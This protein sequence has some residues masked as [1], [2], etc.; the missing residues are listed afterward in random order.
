M[1]QRLAITIGGLA[2]AGVLAVGLGAAGFAPAARPDPGPDQAE[3]VVEAA[4]PTI[5]PEVVYVKPAPPP[6]TVIVTERTR[7]AGSRSGNRQATRVRVAEHEDDDR[8]ERHHE[9]EHEREWEDDEHEGGD[10]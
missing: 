8:R 3:A 10:D 4:D 7:A 9:R 5:E 6:K 2:A 1:R